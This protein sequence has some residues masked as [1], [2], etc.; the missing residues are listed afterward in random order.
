MANLFRKWDADPSARV[1]ESADVVGL[2]V[3][4]R[5]DTLGEE[6]HPKKLMSKKWK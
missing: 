4:L 2:V 5:G 1:A 3:R 6:A